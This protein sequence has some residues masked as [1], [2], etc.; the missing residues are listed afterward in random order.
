MNR[1]DLHYAWCYKKAL[2]IMAKPAKGY[3]II[4]NRSHLRI[5]EGT[6]TH[7]VEKGAWLETRTSMGLWSTRRGM[8]CKFDREDSAA[9]YAQNIYWRLQKTLNHEHV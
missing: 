4:F 2:E 3:S 7:T 1:K 8:V 6:I 5:K 9:L